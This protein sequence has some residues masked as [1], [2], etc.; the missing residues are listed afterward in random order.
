MNK[1]LFNQIDFLA[2]Y[3]NIEWHSPAKLNLFLHITGQREDGY[4]TLQTLFQLLDHGDTLRFE[5]A[6]EGSVTMANP[7]PDVADE[8][9]LIIRAVRLLQAR[10]GR[11]FGVNIHCHKVLPMGGGI[12]G[13]SSNAA[14]T[15]VVLNRL[16]NLGLDIT[17]LTDLGLE[18][19]AD[20]P[21]FVNGI[22]CF[23]SG[24]GEEFAP[25]PQDD[26]YYLVI[27]PEEHIATATIFAHPD[28]PRS[29]PH[30]NWH[31]YDFASTRNDCQ[32]LVVNLYPKVAN[33]LQHLLH[34][35]PSRLTGTGACVFAIFES[36]DTA[37]QALQEL[38]NAHI[39]N[40]K[41]HAFIAKGVHTS[42]LQ[43]Q[44]NTLFAQADKD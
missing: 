14:T 21:V 24:V 12:G 31:D 39:V 35:A 29:N 6:S 22:S 20:V 41:T 2:A 43:T 25:A 34:Y 26:A 15:L 1:S 5:P 10:S 42:P 37:L 13:G 17:E 9:N 18:L 27:H 11:N 23:A 30:L 3:S 36:E 7:L 8:D 19:G 16:L 33:L 4:H 32:E 44:L 40:N 28:L 38:R